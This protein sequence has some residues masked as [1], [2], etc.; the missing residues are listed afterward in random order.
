MEEQ[1][2]LFI[3]YLTEVRRKSE[4]TV[5]CYTRDLRQFQSYCDAQ[6]V[7][8]SRNITAVLLNSYILS[9][10]NKGKKPATVSRSIVSLKAFFQYLMDTRVIDTNPAFDLKPPKVPKKPPTA[11]AEEELAGLRKQISGT[12]PKELRDR[13]MLELLCATGIRVVELLSLKLENVN[14]QLDFIVYHDGERERAVSFG[15]PAKEALLLYLQKGRPFF[16]GDHTSALLFTN[17]SGESM[18]RQGFWKLL[19]YYGEKADI[20]SDLTIAV[21]RHSGMSGREEKPYR[22]TTYR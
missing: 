19:K 20:K 16:V 10:E 15:K 4:N 14:L 21:L 18:S 11:L 8:A 9:M 6:G 2:K 3:R 17:Y 12:S 5:L 13:A 22:Y 1:I 7:T